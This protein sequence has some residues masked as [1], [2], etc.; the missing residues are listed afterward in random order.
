VNPIR[1]SVTT[2]ELALASIPSRLGTSLV[3]VFG[4]GAVVAVFVTV[5]AMAI[6]FTRTADAGGSDSHAVVL[7]SGSPTEAASSLT[8]ENLATIS[9]ASQVGRSAE[10]KPLVSGEVLAFVRMPN[11]QTGLDAFVTLRGVGAQAFALRPQIRIIQGRTF[12]AGK[13]ELIVGRS[14]VSRITGTTVGSS[15]DLPDGA[16][17][18]VGIFASNGDSHESEMMTDA[19]SLMGA[20][21]SA[22]LNSIT[23]SL[24]KPS[25]FEAFK[26]TLSSD[27]TLS[28]DVY[29]ER[30]Y[31]TQASKFVAT[32]FRVIAFGVGGIMAFGAAFGA[33]S[34]MYSAVS[35]RAGEIATLRAIGFGAGPVILSVI[36][37]ALALSLAGAILGSALAWIFFDGATISTLSGT[38]P[39]QVTFALR[40]TPQSV[41]LGIAWACAIGLVGGLFA[42]IRAGRMPVATAMRAA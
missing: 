30:A 41:A 9:S 23:V 42:A 15:I 25:D 5:L 38:T 29:T 35:A 26:A 7:R 34:T 19:A 13:H 2:T 32:L 21:R 33:L 6:G 40:V 14:L 36:V 27:P 20:Y 22:A 10:G 28:V 16:W 39:S 12:V 11:N 1:Q 24:D 4:V 8:L 37:E 17:Q 18:V 3:V 31:L